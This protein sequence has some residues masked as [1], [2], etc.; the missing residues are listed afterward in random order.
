MDSRL[1]Q[2]R[3]RRIEFRKRS[4]RPDR[5]R[6][7]RSTFLVAAA[8][9]TK[10]DWPPVRDTLD[11]NCNNWTARSSNRRDRWS[12]VSRIAI[13]LADVKISRNSSQR[14][15]R[16]FVRLHSWNCRCFSISRRF[17]AH[18]QSCFARCGNYVSRYSVTRVQIESRFDERAWGVPGHEGTACSLRRRCNFATGKELAEPTSVDSARVHTF[19]RANA[20]MR[21]R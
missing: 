10:R 15:A 1:A 9:S 14:K 5:I 6:P 3:N 4:S 16:L 17:G 12:A 18:K 8:A 20:L 11:T 21:A 19:I 7:G 13:S 2:K